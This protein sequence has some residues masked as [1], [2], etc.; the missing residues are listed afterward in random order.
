MSTHTATPW[1]IAED[2]DTEELHGFI[3][4]CS[5]PRHCEVARCENYED[6]A[7][8]VDACNNYDSLKARNGLLTEALEAVID[9][10]EA[11]VVMV[12]DGGLAKWNSAGTVTTIREAR[13]VLAEPQEPNP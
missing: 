1:H 7:I 3:Q 12:R 6:A 4:V 2:I 5:K 9:H 10:L 13:A 11:L 8:I